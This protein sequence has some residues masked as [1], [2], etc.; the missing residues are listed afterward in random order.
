MEKKQYKLC[1]DVLGRFHKAGILEE[2]ILIGSWCVYFYKDY[3]AKGPYLDY[4]ALKTRDMDFLIAEPQKI[5]AQAN[6]PE[7]LKD[8]GFLVDYQGSEGY[9]RLNH[10]DLIVEF[11]VPEKG[12]R[13]HKPQAL[14]K[15]GVNAVALRFLDFL[16]SDTIKVPIENYVIRVPHPI[17]FAL[18]KLIISQR[19][20]LEAKAI[21]DRDMALAL[22]QALLKKGEAP[23]IQEV[24][25]SLLPGWKSRILK[26]LR[27]A[28]EKDILELLSEKI[29]A[30][31]PA[32][33]QA[34]R[35][36]KELKHK[37]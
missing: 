24:F 3:F 18:H 25:K 22:L 5:K 37:G 26:T 16:S 31:L 10:P 9:M 2:L 34:Q 1:H 4:H 14:P 13:H 23:K 21:K 32:G 7:L 29:E 15:L 17:N 19:R 6:V 12:R 30:S 28:D 8:L 36:I 11:L 27:D 33:R 35:I 20:S